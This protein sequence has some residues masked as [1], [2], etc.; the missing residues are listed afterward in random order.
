VSR[1]LGRAGALA[2]AFAAAAALPLTTSIAR[3]QSSVYVP[4][5]DIAY[6]FIDA[7]AARGELAA[8]S[9]LERPY[10]ARQIAAAVAARRQAGERGAVRG[11][12]EAL[13]RA[14]RR[15][16]P[17]A[18]DTARLSVQATAGVSVSAQSSGRREL[19]LAD[20]TSG[21]YPAIFG[22]AQATVGPMVAAWR[23]TADR[24][25]RV[26]PDFAGS[27]KRWITG[28]VED[29]Y[30]AAQARYGEIFLGRQGRN[31]GPSPL[32][33]LQ[34]GPYAYSYD[35]VYARLGP[36]RLHLSTAVARLDDDGEGPD[37]FSPTLVQRY[38]AIHRLA[39][40]WRRLEAAVAEAVLYGGP[41]RGFEL[42][43][44]NPLNVF[45]LAQYNEGKGGNVSYGFDLAYRSS[46]GVYAGQLLYD[47]FQIDRCD[48]AC[49][50]P[51]SYGFS[52]TAEGVPLAGD[53]RGFASYTQV[54]N[55]AYRTPTAFER[56][57][58]D[59]LGIGRGFAD[60]DEVRAGIDVGALPLRLLS[61]AT[62]RVYAAYRRQGEGDYRLPYPTADEF[63]S[64]PTLFQ[65][66]VTRVTR[67]AVQGAMQPAVAVSLSADVGYNLTRNADFVA[68]RRRSQV[69]GRVRVSFEPARLLSLRSSGEGGDIQRKS[70]GP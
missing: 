62:A 26:D 69:E 39:W 25:L 37:P 24:R 66:V 40:R 27:K 68:G 70:P 23:A 11:W 44:A 12:Y 52:L 32:V 56:Y 17:V 8:L 35:H 43:F 67:V 59:D 33:G 57:T 61:G 22:R 13:D 64:T 28:R 31:W 63:A 19:M 30:V 47:D 49:N 58:I 36:E 6:S 7:L 29:A 20:A 41:G 53:Y 4:V 42:A 10:T 50:E 54:T 14:L 60:Y 55:L 9:M 65:G 51:P 2:I 46:R 48:P 1:G 38:L 21:E 45:M 16:A 3:A 15:Y 5:D 34:L 18:D